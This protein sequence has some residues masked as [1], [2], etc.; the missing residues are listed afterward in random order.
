[1][2]A[3]TSNHWK[4]VRRTLCAGVN[5]IGDTIMSMPA[6]DAWRRLHPDAHLSLLVK[7]NLAPLWEMHPGPDG[8]ITYEDTTAG[9]FA[10]GKALRRTGR[11]DRAVV[12]PNSFRSALIPFLAR[13]PER[14]GAPGRFRTFMLTHPVAAS[15]SEPNPSP[16]AA[17]SLS[18]HGGM[19]EPIPASVTRS[20]QAYE[21]FRLLGLDPPDRIEPPR[22]RISEG[23]REAAL[24][25]LESLP[26]PRVALI[27]GAARGPAKRWP[28][29]HFSELGRRLARERACGIALFG[30]PDDS[31]LC[32]G[33]REQ[34]GDNAVNLAGR[35]S[36]KE[37]AALL[38]CC[39]LVIC[40]DSGGMHLAAAVGTP[41]VAIY[42]LTDPAKTGPLGSRCEIIRDEN[43]AA[44]RDIPRDSQ[45]ARAALAAIPPARVLESAL[46]LLG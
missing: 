30:G 9:T 32:D 13:I 14:I 6:I 37:W 19:S 36:L 31:E 35:T 10:I 41:L 34:I 4:P 20:H 12:L 2:T 46:R 5:W 39:D 26:H 29:E 28:A 8:I 7:K 3:S 15:V 24:A 1:M 42:G 23:A 17:S 27:P 44:A 11:F 25:R 16:V 21:Y 45:E 22:L 33:I 18:R 43:A 40:N 38:A